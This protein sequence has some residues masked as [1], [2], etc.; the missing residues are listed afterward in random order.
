[1]KVILAVMKKLKQLQNK[2]RKF[3]VIFILYTSFSSYNRYKLSSTCFQR[4][5]IAQLGEH[6]TSIVKVMGLNPVGASEFFSGLYLQLLKLLH[7]CKDRSLSL[8]FFIRSA[9]T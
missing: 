8:L 2:A 5:F 7:N 9:I 3:F 4:G 6:H 1:M